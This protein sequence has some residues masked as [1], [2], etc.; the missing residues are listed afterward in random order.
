MDLYGSV[1][2]TLCVKINAWCDRLNLFS[3]Y[4]SRW[5]VNLV[6]FLTLFWL[7]AVVCLSRVYVNTYNTS[8]GLHKVIFVYKYCFNTILSN[9]P[10]KDNSCAYLVCADFK[11]C[12]ATK[13][14]SM[15]VNW[16]C[17]KF[18]KFEVYSLFWMCAECFIYSHGRTRNYFRDCKNILK[19][20]NSIQI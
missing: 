12:N 3:V 13:Y 1:V 4:R 6:L 20:C 19:C 5:D 9:A 17:S 11:L 18:I 10:L 15:Y 16:F 14:L 2:F 8:S 7:S